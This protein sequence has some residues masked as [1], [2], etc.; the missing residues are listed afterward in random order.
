MRRLA[1]AVVLLLGSCVPQE[2]PMMSPFQ[3]C[4]SC[5]GSG[6]EGPT[7]TAAGTWAKGAKITIVD[8]QGKSVSL[9]G[10]NAGNFYTAEG[11]A[12][13]ISVSVN[14]VL[15]AASTT[16]TTPLHSTY[17]GCNACHHA[18]AVTVGELMA[19]GANCLTCHGPGGMATTKFVAAGT[20]PPAGRRVKVGNCPQKTTN[21]V[22][23]FYV[24]ASECTIPSF[25]VAASVDTSSMPNGGAPRGGCNGGGCHGANGSADND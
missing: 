6:G 20:F 9:R 3:D 16:P 1:S 14:G 23:N 12:F 19:P 7:W 17:G 21:A 5:H 18:W 8:S 13:P 2:G 10:N 11:L 4:L 24:L 25:P 15:M 22:G